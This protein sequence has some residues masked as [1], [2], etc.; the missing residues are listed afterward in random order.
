[1]TAAT[2]AHSRALD[3]AAGRHLDLLGDLITFK[4][5]TH[6]TNGAYCLFEGR[7]R[8]GGGVP[9]HFHP[10]EDESFYVLH[11]AY[12]FQVGEEQVEAGPGSYVFVPR[13]VVHAFRNVGETPGTL[14]VTVTPGGLHERLFLTF[15]RPVADPSAP[16]LPPSHEAIREFTAGAEQFGTVLVAASA[17]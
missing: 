5:F 10:E 1:M 17:T 11:G 13:G 2:Q 8:P 14:L 7:T 12:R 9:P 4:A 15:G 6:E 16:L 3:P